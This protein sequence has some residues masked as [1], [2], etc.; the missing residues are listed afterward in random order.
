MSGHDFRIWSL[1]VFTGLLAYDGLRVLIWFD[2]MGVRVATLV[3]LTFVGGDKVDEAA[4]R[5]VG[6]AAPT[7]FIPESIR[8]FATWMP[9]LIPFYI[10]RGAEWDI[11]W[12]GAEKLQSHAMPPEISALI[13]DYVLAGLW[14]VAVAMLVARHWTRLRSSPVALMAGV[15]RSL[16]SGRTQFSL[17]NGAIGLNL[18]ADGRGYCHVYETARPWPPI[19]LTRRPTDSLQARGLFFYIRDRDSD[20]LFSLGYEP[21]HVAAPDY[22]VSEDRPGVLTIVNRSASL[23]AEATIRLAEVDCVELWTVR[24]VNLTDHPRRISLTSFQE[25]AMAEFPAY[26][27]DR[28]FFALHVATWFIPPLNA[29]FARNRLLRGGGRQSDQRMSREIF[30]HA[31]RLKGEGAELLGYEDSRIRFL[32]EGDIRKPQGLAEGHARATDDEGLLYSFDPAASLSVGIDLPAGGSCEL[33]FVNG[34]AGDERQAARLAAKYV[35]RA[36]PDETALGAILQRVR[37][38]K[39]EG[40]PADWPFAFS[41]KGDQLMLTESTPRPWGHVLSNPL[42]YGVIVTNDGEIHSFAGNERQNA[43]TPYTFEPVPSTM[44]GQ[45]IYIVDIDHDEIYCPGFVPLRRKDTR[46]EV[47]FEKGVAIFR[48]F[49]PDLDL[50][51]T[52]FVPP[53]RAAD[54]R[55]LTIRNKT[56]VPRR[57]RI[58]PYFD[59]ALAETPNESAGRIEMG[60]DAKTNTV[61]FNNPANSFYKGVGFVATSLDITHREKIRAR[62][63]GAAGRDLARPVMAVTGAPDPHAGDDGRRIV[64]GTAMIEIEAGG[65]SGC[66]IVLGQEATKAEAL[67]TAEALREPKRAR[68]ALAETRAYWRENAPVIEIESNH[69]HFDRLV[70]HWLHYEA[71]ACR[72]YARGGPNQRSGAFGYRDQLQDLLGVLFNDPALARK[73]ILLHASQQF[74][75]GD[76]LKWWHQTR[77]GRTGL[78]QRSRASDPHLWLP[79]VTTRYI[80]ATGD[81]A[82]LRERT[83]YLAGPTVPLDVDSLTFVPRISR[84]SGDLYEHCRLALDYTL[85]HFGAHGLPL[86]GTGDWN[87]GIDH[88]GFKGHGESVWMGFF[89]HGIL[90]DFAPFIVARDGHTAAAPYLDRADALKAA[91]DKTWAGDHYIV[92]YSDSGVVLDRYGTMTA[93]WPILTGAVESKRGLAA[94]EG[95]LAKLEKADRI[96]LFDQPFD[97]LSSPFPGR[98]ADYPPGLRENGGQYTHGATWL[99]DAY[100]E[101]AERA[102]KKGDIRANAQ[103]KARAFE[104][105]RKMSPLDKLEGEALA[106][107]G[108]APHQQPADIS[109]G[110]GHAGRGGWSWYT[111]AAARMLTSAY[112]L[113]G[114][115]MERGE[116]VVPD[117]IFEPK[118]K[119]TIRSLKIRGKPY[120][121]KRESATAGAAN[122]G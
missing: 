40:D 22:R 69:P 86:F 80:T 66:T 105:W 64:S 81:D 70:N 9:L 35:A 98:I 58:V 114:L 43:V 29:V 55:L 3:N 21:C 42:G 5:A 118:G 54:V 13:G 47:V 7:R 67:A 122:K 87:D 20:S 12:S 38:L 23:R 53:D 18:Q 77:D 32:G 79:Y 94:L 73:Q 103:H 93:A 83:H 51:L 90:Q 91:L 109:E 8:R 71:V 107:Y 52:L 44:P 120:E 14:C 106:I 2:H 116:I 28:D 24:L 49:A 45:I 108:L 56:S 30:F 121:R 25:I 100:V 102:Q 57:F 96:L 85:A 4:A 1:V 117:D 112:A 115:R 99:V 95:P 10:P 37:A 36:V 11:A 61:L 82:I 48:S 34:H 111:G 72:L 88:L 84:V 19:D 74:L 17:S 6:Y 78:G 39:T 63:I 75:E 41:P 97:E 15:P 31:V 89:L 26:V 60:F 101:L 59:L 110:L 119:L 104:L 62:F 92:G 76:V 46:Q 113:L 68:Q 33:L 27:R 16:A 50:E 65:E